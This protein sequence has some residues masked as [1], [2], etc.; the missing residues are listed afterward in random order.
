MKKRMKSLLSIVAILIFFSITT[1]SISANNISISFEEE[2]DD[3]DTLI[4]NLMEMGKIPSLSTCIIKNDTIVWAKS[5]GYQNIYLR[6]KSTNDTIYPIGSVS[7][8]ITA[9]AVMQLYEKGLIDL[10]EDVSNYLGFNLRNPKYPEVPITFRLLLSHQSGI[11]NC[12][13]KYSI[14]TYLPDPFM[15][16]EKFL[17]PGNL[18]YYSD[19][20][21]DFEPGQDVCYSTT[22]FDILSYLVEIVSGQ[23][24]NDY[25]K[26][27][28]FH[29]L[30]MYNTSCYYSDFNKEKLS[31]SYKTLINIYL[32]M[33]RL[34]TRI[35][36]GGGIKTNVIDLGHFLIAHMNN[37]T[38]KESQILNETSI[39]LMHQIHEPTYEDIPFGFG[40]HYWK[41]LDDTFF[42]GHGGTFSNTRTEMRTL[43]D[44]GV[45]YIWNYDIYEE[46][47]EHKQFL[48][49]FVPLQ[50]QKALF[51]KADGLYI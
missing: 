28:I 16:L 46:S 27:N 42:G 18:F 13:M 49:E 11:T 15:L 45:I 35:F 21:S 12:Y 14:F 2:V 33:P 51:E 1:N 7:K 34:N 40:W 8:S 48:A 37:G 32:P 19:A 43:G 44:I 29:P 10:D 50:I 47:D 38:Y 39:S 41:D 4:N 20:W 30:E 25:C 3:F 5:Y 31:Y 6:R 22:G 26:E 17:T 24:F 36:G 23:S 9:T